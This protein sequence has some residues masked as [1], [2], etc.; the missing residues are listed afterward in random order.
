MGKQAKF[1][2]MG[3]LMI[4]TFL[5]IYPIQ[6]RAAPGLAKVDAKSYIIIDFASGVI[7]DGKMIETPRPP[8]SMTKMMTEFIILDQI[9]AGKLRWEEEVTVPKRVTAIDEAQIYL[10]AGEK[11]TV[12]ELFIAMAVQSANDAAVALAEHVGGSEEAFVEQMNQKAVELGMKHTHYR[13]ST[14]L[15]PAVSSQAEGKH[16]MSA[17]DAAI[18]A[19]QLIKAHANMLDIASIPTY[20]FHKGTKQ[21]QK[22]T[23]SNWMLPGLQ[24]VYQGVDGVKTGYTRAAGYCFTGT[25]KRGEV[26]LVTV[27]MAARSQ[28][29]RFAETKKLLDYGFEQF[30]LATLVAEQA[31]IPGATSL[32]LSNGVERTVPIVVRTKIQLPVH[33]GEREKYRVEVQLQQGL[34]APLAAGTVVGSARVLYDGKEVKGLSEYEVV[35]QVAVAEASGFRLFLREI[36]DTIRGWFL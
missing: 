33:I 30:Q 14:G 5:L 9:A 23:N 34:K 27:V 36:G 15:D 4:C 6:V 28:I 22:V 2:K 35:T 17:H 19:V 21:E 29:G 8:A 20:T 25:A 26:R 3:L 12:R 1:Y 13:N 7:L 16:E 11:K 18:L 10:V 31:S 32:P 24:Q